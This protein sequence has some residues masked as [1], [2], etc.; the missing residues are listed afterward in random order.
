[1]RLLFF[2]I[3]VVTTKQNTM[4]KSNYFLKNSVFGQLI[5]FY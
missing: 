1:M 2:S 5:F 4:N 3:F